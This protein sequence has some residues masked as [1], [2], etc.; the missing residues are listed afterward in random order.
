MFGGS[1]RGGTGPL[2]FGTENRNPDSFGE[3]RERT[4]TFLR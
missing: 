3:Q 2:C 4:D 1:L